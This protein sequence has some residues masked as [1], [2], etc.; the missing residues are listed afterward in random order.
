MS[1]TAASWYERLREDLRL[2]DYRATTQAS[3]LQ[4]VR[5]F[6]EHAGREPADLMEEDVRAYALHLRDVKGVSA[7]TTKIAFCA[8]RFFFEHTVPREWTVF[9]LVRAH[10][11][12]TLPVVLSRGEVRKLLGSVRDPVRRVALTTIYALGLRLHEGLALEAGDIDGAR[13]TVW[14]RDGKG[15]KQRGVPLPRPLLAKL[16]EYWKSDRPPATSRHLFP[17]RSGAGPM[18]DST[19]QKTFTAVLRES[20]VEK[21]A[22]IHTLRHSYATHLLE[23]GI[24][25]RT[26]QD[27][28]GHASLRTTSVYM[29][30]T[31]PA[32]EQLQKTLDLL[33]LAL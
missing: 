23:A 10:R 21:K 13:L 3:Y 15:G 17:S 33:M 4:A 27:V 31:E 5:S 14:V 24:S 26:I 25:L 32:V 18:H 22:T 1:V 2:H 9:D 7:S 28:L 12:R 16:R 30:V 19:L 29:H 20:N 6:I 11:P 8:L